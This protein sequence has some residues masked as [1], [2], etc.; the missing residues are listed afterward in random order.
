MKYLVRKQEKLKRGTKDLA[1]Q[2]GATN[3]VS[4]IGKGKNIIIIIGAF[5]LGTNKEAT[6]SRRR[7]LANVVAKDPKRLGISSAVSQS[8]FGIFKGGKLPH[9]RKE[10]P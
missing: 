10:P 2:A 6:E 5:F 4:S 1:V 7:H 3:I 8:S 9:G